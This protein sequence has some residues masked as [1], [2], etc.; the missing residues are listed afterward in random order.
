MDHQAEVPRVRRYTWDDV[1]GLASSLSR[2]IRESQFSPTV[3]VAVLRGGAFPALLLSHLLDVRRMYAVRAITTVDE[4]PRGERFTPHVEGALGIPPLNDEVVLLV[5]DVTNTG[6]TLDAARSAIVSTCSPRELFTA[7]MLW[8]TVSPA[9]AL[10]ALEI[11]AADFYAA[12]IH[13]WVGFPW[14]L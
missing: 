9:S 8:D 1:I 4:S 11:C 14:E 10:L 7:A 12:D 13:A 5:D 6:S 3:I 2:A